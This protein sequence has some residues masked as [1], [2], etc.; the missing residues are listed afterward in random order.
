MIVMIRPRG[1][2][3]TYDINEFDIMKEDITVCKQLGVK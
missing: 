3:F 1:G 2:D